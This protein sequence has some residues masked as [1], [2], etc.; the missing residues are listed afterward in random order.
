M[1]TST[2]ARSSSPARR[3]EK[4]GKSAAPQLDSHIQAQLGTLL[5][6]MYGNLLNE[7]VPERFTQILN[8]FRGRTPEDPS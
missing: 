7:P 2:K 4:N 8:G 5:Q 6:R 1:V 3:R